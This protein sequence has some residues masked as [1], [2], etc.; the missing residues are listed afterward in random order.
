M[1]GL[2]QTWGDF[3][4]SYSFGGTW[5]ILLLPVLLEACGEFLASCSFGGTWAILMLPGSFGSTFWETIFLLEGYLLF[6][7]LSFGSFG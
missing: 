1:D 4:A 6:A 5:G 3:V 2:K 7:V